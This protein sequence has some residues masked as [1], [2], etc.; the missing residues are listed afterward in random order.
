VGTR[1]HRAVSKRALRGHDAEVRHVGVGEP[2]GAR[3]TGL[4]CQLGR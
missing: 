4:E 2:V 1:V 3:R